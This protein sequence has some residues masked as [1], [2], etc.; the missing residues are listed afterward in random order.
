MKNTTAL[1]TLPPRRKSVIKRQ[2]SIWGW[3]FV[4]LPIL[5]TAVFVLLPVVLSLYTSFT[6]WYTLDPFFDAEKKIVGFANYK[7]MLTDK[8]TWQTL[9]NTVFYMIGVPIGMIASLLLAICMNRKIVGRNAFRVIYYI[10]VVASVVSIT[11]LFTNLFEREGLINTFLAKI[12]GGHIKPVEWM[13]NPHLTKPTVILMMTWKGL[14]G[15]ILLFL[16]GLQ[17]VNQTYYEAAKLD[18]AGNVKMFFK[19]TMPQLTPVIFYVLVTSV[20]G[21]FQLF[22]EPQLFYGSSRNP[23]NEMPFVMYLYNAYGRRQGGLSTAMGMFLGL[24]VMVVTLIQF[25]INGRRN[26]D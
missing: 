22:T 20:I 19:I 16:A 24:L 9:G 3:I 18:G 25:Y 7:T 2:D 1:S 21:G 10:P 26:K 4:A 11:L 23:F 15:T 12:S 8:R 5:G 6:D 14:G 17:G 13:T